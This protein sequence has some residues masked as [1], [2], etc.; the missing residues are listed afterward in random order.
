MSNN[1]VMM[2]VYGQ[3]GMGKTTFAISATG[4][5]L[6]DFDR[7]VRR[8]DPMHTIGKDVIQA[9]SY[10][11]L[12]EF[13]NNPNKLEMYETIVI[14]SLSRLI[15]S[16]TDDLKTTDGTRSGGLKIDAWQKLD[17]IFKGIVRQLIQ[18]EQNVIFV[19]H[20]K[21]IAKESNDGGQILVKRPSSREKNVNE[22]LKD[23]DLVG[24]MHLYKNSRRIDFNAHELY[25]AKNTAGFNSIIDIPEVSDYNGTLAGILQRGAEDKEDRE[26]KANSVRDMV[27]NLEARVVSLNTLDEYNNSLTQ[28]KE[29]GLSVLECNY[30]LELLKK[31]G[32]TKGFRFDT[33]SKQFT[34]RG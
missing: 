11:T 18:C 5:I 22:L 7:G 34:V 6:F 16:I 10:K 25:Y 27:A 19:D 14:D 4:T 1:K 29:E 20:E 9:P 8:V 12:I 24:Y 2:L 28:A 17:N 33:N 31:Y 23:L 21:E 30:L 32:R 15:D 3:S 13:L 26:S